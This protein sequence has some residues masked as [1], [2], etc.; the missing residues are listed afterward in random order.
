[1]RQLPEQ[2]VIAARP[3]DAAALPI[4]DH[5]FNWDFQDEFY[6]RR[7]AATTVVT[8]ACSASTKAASAPPWASIRHRSAASDA[9]LFDLG[10]GNYEVRCLTEKGSALFSGKTEKSDRTGQARPGSRKEIRSADGSRVCHRALRGPVLAEHALT[11]LGC[12]ACALRAPPA[13]ASTLWMPGRQRAT[14][15]CGPGTP[16][17]SR[18]S[19]RTLPATIRARRSPAAS[20][21]ASCTSSPSIRRSSARSSAPAAATAPATARRDWAC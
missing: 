17:S 10:D 4:L 2:I 13:T 19:R 5:V 11:C 3:C 20:G 12:G 16:A 7:R 1:M 14:P 9:M 6:N 21:S 18:C 15:A 8:L